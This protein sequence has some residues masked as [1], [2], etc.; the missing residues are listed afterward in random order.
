MARTFQV[1]GV[2]VVHMRGAAGAWHVE[3]AT[4]DGHTFERRETT[5]GDALQAATNAVVNLRME[6]RREQRAALAAT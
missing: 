2:V 6:Q 4:D 1:L 3:L 5:V